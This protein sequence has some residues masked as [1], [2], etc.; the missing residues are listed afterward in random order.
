M[1]GGG[2]APGC[3]AG[4][5]LATAGI[6]L[7]AAG[8]GLHAGTESLTLALDSALS[9]PDLHFSSV[10]FQPNRKSIGLPPGV[11][12]FPGNPVISGRIKAFSGFWGQEPAP[13]LSVASG[14]RLSPRC[15]VPSGGQRRAV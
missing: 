9:D 15:A 12:R 7:L 8:F 2:L 13:A 3:Q 1:W 14:R 11:Q 10:R 5:S 4:R 6:D